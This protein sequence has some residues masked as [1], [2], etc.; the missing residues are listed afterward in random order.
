MLWSP[1]QT[2]K[3]A[4]A[5]VEITSTWLAISFAN[6]TWTRQRPESNI[7]KARPHRARSRLRCGAAIELHLVKS[8]VLATPN[9]LCIAA[10]RCR[11]LFCEMPK[12]TRCRERVW[13]GPGITVFSVLTTHSLPSCALS[14]SWATFVKGRWGLVAACACKTSLPARH[15]LAFVSNWGGKL[16]KLNFHFS[17]SLFHPIAANGLWNTR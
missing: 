8:T 3:K 9:A 15:K 2:P 10:L 14:K 13:C 4:H 11:A 16:G 12:E 5:F 6:A 7:L 17:K 1:W